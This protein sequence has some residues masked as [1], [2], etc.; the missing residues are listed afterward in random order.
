MSVEGCDL[1]EDTK[2]LEGMGQTSGEAFNGT[3]ERGGLQT[4][5]NIEAVRS[6]LKGEFQFTRAG[7]ANCENRLG[8]AQGFSVRNINDVRLGASKGFGVRNT[9]T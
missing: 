6:T 5:A 7:S 2:S 1:R 4:S 3:D 8:A 9:K